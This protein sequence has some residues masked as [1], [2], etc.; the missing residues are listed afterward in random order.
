MK[1]FARSASILTLSSL[2]AWSLA[3][4]LF[5]SIN[6]YYRDG[7]LT[8]GGYGH[9]GHLS[10]EAKEKVIIESFSNVSISEWSYYYTSGPHLG[11]RNYSQAEWTLEKWNESGIPSSIVTYNVF[12][13]YPISHNLSLTYPNGS[14]FNATLEEDVLPEDS[15]TSY[16]NRIPTFHGYSHTGNATAEYVYVG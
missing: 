5:S 6:R 9:C 12:L 15:T 13:N 11:G 2:A 8:S 10:L 7:N 1:L 14:V 16:P 3:G 4:P